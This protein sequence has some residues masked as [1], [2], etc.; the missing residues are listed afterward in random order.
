MLKQCVFGLLAM[1]FCAHLLYGQTLP[2]AVL[3]TEG[4]ITIVQMNGQPTRLPLCTYVV[5]GK[6]QNTQN[7]VFLR[8][9]AD[10]TLYRQA[11]LEIAVWSLIPVG[12]AQKLGLRFAN[13]TTADTLTIENIVPL[14]ES[15]DRPYIT[16]LG[17][18][19]LS[20]THLFL[21]G[22]APVNVIVPDNAWNLGYAAVTSTSA[23]N[24]CALS[25]RI[26]WSEPQARRRRFETILY[27][28]GTVTYQ[29]WLENYQGDWQAGLRRVFQQRYLYDLEGQTFND[30]LY[31]RP[32]QQWIRHAYAMHLLMAWDRDFYDTQSQ[33]YKLLDFIKKG[34]PLYGGDDVVGIW[35][36]WPMLGLDQRN[37]WD[38]FRDL[39]GGKAKLGTLANQS[40]ALGARFFISYNPW[41]ES[42]RWEDH[43]KG[44][45]A[46][47]GGIGAD[48]V[49]LDTEGKSTPERQR[50]VDQ[51]RP[52][53]IMYSE[54]MAVP[55]DM[56]GI[57]SG[58]VHNAL[59]YPPL[60]NLNK[61]IRPD[62]A[63]FRV[64]ELYLEPIRREYAVSFFNGYGTEINQFRP[65]RPTWIDEDYRFW[66]RTLRILRENTYNFTGANY[67]PLITSLRD[68]IYI[69]AWPGAEKTIYTLFS[70]QAAGFAGDL[71]VVP[72]R[73]VTH[74]VVDLWNHEL[75]TPKRQNDQWLIPAD[76]EGFSKKWLG[77]N[78][79][80]AVGAIAVFPKLL[81]VT[82]TGDQ[83]AINANGGDTILIW[84]GLPSYDKKPYKMRQTGKTMPLS[85]TQIFGRKE[86][87]FV[88][89]LLGQ[90]D[91][92]DEQVFVLEP[93]LA[94]LVSTSAKTTPAI[95]PPKDMAHIPAGRFHISITFGDNFIPNPKEYPVNE[96]EM[97]AF[98]MDKHPVTNAQFKVFLD[99]THYRPRDTL[100]FL[101]HWPKGVIKKG[102]E[103]FP[104]IY[105]SYEDAL[106]YAR[107]AGKRL[108]TEQE[109]QYAAQTSDGREWPWSKN[110]TVK[111]EQQVITETLT[112]SKLQVD[113]TLCN[114]GNGQL[115]PVGRYPKGANP[116]G[117]EDLVG[118]VWQLTNDVYDNGTNQFLI[119]KGGSYYL[120]ASSWWY[121]EGGPREL[122]YAQ[123][124]LRV[125]P[126]WERNAAT[127]F[128][129]VKD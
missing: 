18:H 100:R 55:K 89:Q 88:V 68:S 101:R 54:G 56:P 63:I 38:L 67:T 74:H 29:V 65:G 70:L 59:Y 105:I 113:S 46:M 76:L 102:E 73:E 14:G 94:R 119:L 108:P 92:L 33:Q 44:M 118:C 79:E 27:P 9:N 111:R 57:L 16:G 81:N 58:R 36:N 80:G 41:D 24:V 125:A 51:E 7:A 75:I 77:T 30:S 11:G 34:Q 61:L 48:G 116:Y 45:A 66:G 93:G 62:F 123:K 129:C 60:L 12:D 43:H 19:P 20:R 91:L 83:L 23:I 31:R 52:G 95:N 3:A 5:N 99:K 42:T 117:L 4:G 15:A 53:V 87:K 71:F 47:I 120:P 128:R 64:A 49:V 32:D 6:L 28:Q 8:K 26:S 124:L 106:S 35:P 112:V 114:T 122:N 78:N 40:R 37:Q 115:Y 127:G 72:A 13:A 98:W 121:V 110:A 90:K 86:G 2:N 84:H 25:R 22:R 85:L 103:N 39:P 107:W 104:V 50:A 17:K 10:T 69:N 96:V 82:R 21:P 1:L 126:G 109:W 97:P